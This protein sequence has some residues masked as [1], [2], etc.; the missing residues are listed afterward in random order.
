MLIMCAG[1]TTMK[2]ELSQTA[3]KNYQLT[4][5]LEKLPKRSSVHLYE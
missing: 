4:I 2:L 1:A 3:M 5:V